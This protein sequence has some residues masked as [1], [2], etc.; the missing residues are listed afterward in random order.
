MEKITCHICLKEF[1][2]GDT[3]VRDR[4][5]YTGKYRGPAQRICNLRY[6]I[7]NYIPIVFHNLSR[8]NAHLLIRELGKKFNTGKIGVIAEN[9]DNCISFNVDVIVDSYT[10][11]SGEIKEKKIQIYR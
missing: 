4:C 2:K 6:K 11:N 10:N 9:K 7:S 5:H 1:Q 8:Y 3:K